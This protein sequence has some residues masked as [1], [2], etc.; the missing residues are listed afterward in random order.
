MIYSMSRPS[1][2]YCFSKKLSVNEEQYAINLLLL[3]K[4]IDYLK[5]LYEYRVITDSETIDDVKHLS[6]NI[7]F[8]DTSNFI[9][10]EDLKVKCISLLKK[11]EVIVDP[12]LFIFQQLDCDLEYDLIFEHKDSQKKPWYRDHLKKL[13]GTLLYDKIILTGKV[14]FVPN[15]GFFKI[16]NGKLLSLFVEEYYK[17]REDIINKLSGD[18]NQYNLLLGQYLLGIILY[19]GNFSYLDL[20]STNSAKVYTH[21]AGPDKYRK[22]KVNKPVI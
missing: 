5:D 16:T 4:S 20:R 3:S 15:I 17:Y 12:D 19:E 21:M 14:P 6:T 1:F 7:E 8:I 13:K 11:N 2:V 10:L 22:Y 18:L 9:F